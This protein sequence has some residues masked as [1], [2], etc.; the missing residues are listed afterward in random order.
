ML[1]RRIILV[2]V[3]ARL[4]IILLQLLLLSILLASC[5]RSE[6]GRSLAKL[7]LMSVVLGSDTVRGNCDVPSV[8]IVAF[9]RLL[10]LHLMC[11]EHHNLPW[12]HRL[13]RISNCHWLGRGS[14]VVRGCCLNVCMRGHNSRLDASS[15]QG[16]CI[17]VRCVDW[18]F[19]PLFF[20]GLLILGYGSSCC[21]SGGRSS[22]LKDY[23]VPCRVRGT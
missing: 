11:L 5:I 23:L 7:L 16:A 17:K 1:G 13:R 21:G 12:L 15:H 2:L 18:R 22:L 20:F 6:L 9:D 14:E 4:D 3:L 10:L 19:L 8:L